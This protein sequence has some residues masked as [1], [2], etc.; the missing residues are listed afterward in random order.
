[1]SKS[2]LITRP[3]N[4]PTTNY[5]FYWSTSVINLAHRK[6]FRVID[7]SK[8]KANQSDFTSRVDKTNPSFVFFNGHGDETMI[9]GQNEE[10]LISVKRNLSLLKN[11]IVFARSCSSAKKLGIKSIFLGTKAFIGYK[12][13]FIFMS[14]PLMIT[15]PLSDATAALF[16]KPSNLVASTL[17]KGHSASEANARAKK[18][19]KRNIIKLLTRETQ[20]EDSSALR[21]LFWDMKHQVFLGDANA[22]LY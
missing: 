1:M 6:N 2:L 19:F 7:L 14:D 10:I 3:N 11:R 20:K 9:L 13:P 15:K 22:S 17:L 21:F 4:D 16:L 5:L 18:A 12:E 8:N